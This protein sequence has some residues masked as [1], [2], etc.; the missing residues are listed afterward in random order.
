MSESRGAAGV[1]PGGGSVLPHRA[2]SPGRSYQ[3]LQRHCQDI[4][5][6]AR[7]NQ[8]QLDA[9]PFHFVGSLVPSQHA[10]L[11]AIPWDRFENLGP[12]LG[13]NRPFVPP[14]RCWAKN[15]P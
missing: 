9:S 8:E 6:I 11:L 2:V 1:R 3:A 10:D 14:S 4:T 7:R 13:E 5:L 12:S 15:A